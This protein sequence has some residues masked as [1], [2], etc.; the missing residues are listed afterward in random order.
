[1]RQKFLIVRLF[2][3]E[4]LYAEHKEKD[5][6]G[7]LVSDMTAGPCL[8][9]CLAKENA[10]AAWR[11]KLGP[12]TNAAEEEPES[13]RARFPS[14]NFNAIHAATSPEAFEREKSILFGDEKAIA[15]IKPD[16]IEKV[17]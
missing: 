16:G 2:L 15:L 6:Y 11:E 14:G 7:D 9:L 3:V 4:L 5:F 13:L 1:M 10:I 17:S 12:A 8:V